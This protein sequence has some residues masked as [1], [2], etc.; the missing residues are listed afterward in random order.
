MIIL[1]IDPGYERLGV[2]I[3]KKEKDK[4]ELLYSSC[5]FT[6]SSLEFNERLN[7]IQKE[8]GRIIKKYNATDLSIETLFFNK[9]KKTAL[10]VSEIR[11]AIIGEAMKNN[12]SVHEYTPLQIKMAL[13]GYGRADKKQISFMVGKLLSIDVSL[14]IDDECDAIATA[15]TH[16]SHSK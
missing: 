15:I 7:L 12:L 6:K 10:R 9:N 16:S 4:E 3:L 14:K 5:F 2:A 11:G 8:V 13:T 1:G